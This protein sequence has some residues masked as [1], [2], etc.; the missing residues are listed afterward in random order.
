MAFVRAFR[1]TLNSCIASVVVLCGLGST[2]R[3]PKSHV[4]INGELTP[5]ICKTN[6]VGERVSTFALVFAANI[7]RKSVL[8]LF[9]PIDNKNRRS[10]FRIVLSCGLRQ[11]L[12]TLD[13]IATQRGKVSLELCPTQLHRSAVFVYLYAVAHHANASFT[14]VIDIRNKVQDVGKRARLEQFAMLHTHNHS[15]SLTLNHRSFCN[16]GYVRKFYGVLH[17]GMLALCKARLLALQKE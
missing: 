4:T 10:A 5:R 15:V 8:V 14:I 12:Q 3:S 9:L 2:L 16:N 13:V 7:P 11:N 17:R 1:H 6:K